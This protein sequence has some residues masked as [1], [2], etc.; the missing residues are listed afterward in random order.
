[1]K[2]NIYLALVTG[3]VLL[4]QGCSALGIPTEA[5][6][7][8]PLQGDLAQNLN[9]ILTALQGGD[10]TAAINAIFGTTL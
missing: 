4:T 6:L 2:K 5:S 1:M 3:G 9:T 7:A 10:L 8:H